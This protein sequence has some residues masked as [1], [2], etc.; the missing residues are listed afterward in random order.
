MASLTD[1]VADQLCRELEEE[2][3]EELWQTVEGIM[4]DSS[5]QQQESFARTWENT[6]PQHR[7]QLLQEIILRDRK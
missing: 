2:E 6:L 5:Y 3:F 1:E 4:R 7:K